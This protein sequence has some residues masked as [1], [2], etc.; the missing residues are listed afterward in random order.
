LPRQPQT[1][2]QKRDSHGVLLV[3]KPEGITSHDL[4]Q[5]VRKLVRP[6]KV[7]H[8]GTLDS[9]ASGLMVL[10]IGAGTR[11][12]DY[13]DEGRKAYSMK[14]LLGEET[15]TG[16]REGSITRTG[17]PSG[18]S[19]ET[20][21]RAL[22]KYR[23]VIDQIP[24]HHSAIK[25][26][27]VRLYKLARKGVFPELS[28]RK[29]EIFLL[30]LLRWVPPFLELEMVCSKGTYARSVARDVGQDLGVGGRLETLRRTASGPFKL[31]DAITVE[32]MMSGGV[33]II[34]EKLINIS[35]ALSHIPRMQL[36]LAEIKKLMCG[37]DVVVPRNRMPTTNSGEEHKS[38]LFKIVPGKE[39]LL[40][41]VRPEPKG[42]DISLR[43]VRV[44]NM[45]KEE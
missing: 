39:D 28:P 5:L 43:P 25:K 41:L 44:F 2:E 26:Q 21:E 22:D 8:S 45:W 19:V 1:S 23:G 15:D 18:I 9:A 32:Q 6:S 16:D 12:L 31:E 29:V 17:D 27:G 4:V 36:Q 24:P 34:S 7:G 33:Q 37:A 3:D 10:L 13:L 20:I 40:I 35:A 14:V 11:A 38:Q 42:S 30:E